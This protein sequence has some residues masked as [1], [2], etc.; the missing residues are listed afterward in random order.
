M[1]GVTFAPGTF[2]VLVIAQQLQAEIGFF[3]YSIVSYCV[4][5]WNIFILIGASKQEIS[6]SY[7]SVLA[8]LFLITENF[9][10]YI[11]LHL[12]HGIEMRALKN[13][14]NNTISTCG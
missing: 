13:Y 6:I 7:T 10:S 14:E 12:L 1:S 5:R 8:E 2:I 9:V 3:V 11:M 4:R